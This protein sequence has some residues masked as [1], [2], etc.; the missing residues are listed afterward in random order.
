MRWKK[1]Y[2]PLVDHRFK[3]KTAFLWLPKCL[4]GEWRWWEKATWEQ[5]YFTEFEKEG[6]MDKRWVDSVDVYLEKYP[7]TRLEDVI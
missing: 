2:S 1:K 7:L 3:L 6:Y 4:G 5:Q